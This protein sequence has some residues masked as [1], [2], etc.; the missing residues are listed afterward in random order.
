MSLQRR[1]LL[2]LL[3]SAPL[4]W[5]LALLFSVIGA[6]HSVNEL[7]DTELIRL[8]RQVQV[9][10]RYTGAGAAPSI[11]V[12]A[13]A[14]ASGGEADL[15]DM[16]IAVWDGQGH[17]LVADRE[18]AEL[19]YRPQATGFV[20]EQLNGQAWRLY[21][22]QSAAGEWLVAS[23]QKAK[24]RHE[25]VIGLTLTQLFPW[26]LVL[27]V[28]LAAM[29]WAIRRALVPVHAMATELEQR[30]ADDLKP[31][32]ENTAPA[33]IKPLLK[34]M[35]SLFARI[36]DTLTRE[37]RFTADAAHEL[38][39][40]LA[41]LRAQWDVLRLSGGPTERSQAE[42][43]LAA[44]LD[45]MDRLVTQMLAL[46]RVE[47]RAQNPLQPGAAA[48]WTHTLNWPVVVEQAISDCLPLADRRNIDI[49]CEWPDPPGQALAIPGD[50]YLMTILLRNLLDNAVRYAPA[51]T[52]V[53]LLFTPT[54]LAIHNEG[55][56]LGP[57]EL[58]RL[59]ERFYR[60][61][62]QRESGSGLGVSI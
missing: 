38:R 51:N 61:D 25:L 28:L 40:P 44:G 15:S 6:R 12:P 20:D 30:H 39:T 50:Q 7:F 45:R 13:H 33:E 48:H 18:G 32:P 10:V 62:G 49:A 34:A 57:A 1:L 35:N 53:K 3:I 17:L 8:A 46:A 55:A 36:D 5:A 29:A 11:P 9:L 27:P 2:Y 41:V 23:G 22:L 54:S 19:P 26:L 47:A 16:A 60:P 42:T 37:R 58:A 24:E 59:G 31:L 43:R 4:V 21:Y 56:A 14:P 52:L